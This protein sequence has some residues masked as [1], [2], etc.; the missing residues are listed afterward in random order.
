MRPAAVFLAIALAGCSAREVTNEDVPK[1][2]K[3]FETLG[4]SH[5]V[6]P[7]VMD[8]GTRCVAILGSQGRAITCDWR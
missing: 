8:D 4:T 2:W 1:G 5:F 6:A 7:L 3:R